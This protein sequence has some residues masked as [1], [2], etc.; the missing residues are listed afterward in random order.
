MLSN[1]CVNCLLDMK[2]QGN[3]MET[4]CY[5]KN[6]SLISQINLAAVKKT[7]KTKGNG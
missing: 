5:I 1:C 6:M 3:N 2:S 4:T 7:N